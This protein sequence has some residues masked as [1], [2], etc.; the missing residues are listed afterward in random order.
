M[1]FQVPCLLK[2]GIIEIR[3]ILTMWYVKI[4]NELTKNSTN[5][6]LY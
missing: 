3:V 4:L 2:N 5:A 6:I 1:M